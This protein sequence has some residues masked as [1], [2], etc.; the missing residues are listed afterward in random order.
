MNNKV[1]I[2]TQLQEY[3]LKSAHSKTHSQTTEDNEDAFG[4][5][6]NKRVHESR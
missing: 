2:F 3:I 5:M 6:T 4:S 1:V